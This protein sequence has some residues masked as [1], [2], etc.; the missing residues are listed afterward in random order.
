MANYNPNKNVHQKKKNSNYKGY[1]AAKQEAEAAKNPKPARPKVPFWVS[2]TMFAI[3]ALLIVVLVL[4]NGVM[5]DNQY[6]AQ[7]SMLII[8]A[9]CGVISFLNRFY[10]RENSKLQ[11]GLSIALAVM[12][13]VYV[14]MGGYGLWQLLF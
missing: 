12:A 9:S 11:N 14:V 5:K 4:T 3:F 8:G 2:F 1:V 10:Q 6:F 7:G 13:V